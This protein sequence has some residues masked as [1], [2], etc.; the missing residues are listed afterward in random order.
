MLGNVDVD[1]LTRRVQLKK[2]EELTSQIRK[3]AGFIE[4]SNADSTQPMAI[5]SKADATAALVEADKAE[6]ALEK[7]KFF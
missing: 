5:K 3:M 4:R 6:E 2:N 1:D 7:S